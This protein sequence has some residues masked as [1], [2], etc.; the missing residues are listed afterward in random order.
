MGRTAKILVAGAGGA[1]SEGVIHSLNR[2]G[3]ETVGMGSE[4]T[5][6][7][8]SAASRKYW[9]P[10]ANAPE[11]K[12]RLLEILR[13]E[14]PD[15]VHFQNDLEIYHASL[16]RDEIVETGVK[17]FM[18]SHETIDACVHKYKSWQKFKAAGIKVPE[19]ILIHNEE[20]LRR[21]FDTLGKQQGNI[22]LR[23]SSIGGGGKG[24]LPTSSFEFAKAWIDHYKGWGDFVA[25]E[26]LT[27]D[28]VTWLSI[29]REGELIVAQGRARQGWTHGSRAV[30]GI[31]G[32]TKVGVTFSSPEL[33]RIAESTI[34]AVDPKPHGIYGV[35]L[36]YD[37]EGV[38]N[39]TEINIS[40][41][42]T[43]ILFFTEA[44]LNMPE[45]FANLALFGERPRLEKVRSPLKDGLMWLR[46][47]DRAPMLCTEADLNSQIDYGRHS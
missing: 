36:A 41:F 3:F 47:M 18:P 5:D 11:Y 40:R 33:D 31:T 34:R 27:K 21:A 29:W 38:P 9:V 37:A 10:Y 6:L 22:W 23:A 13:F 30:S 14:K 25:A 43:T 46:G 32:V 12:G 4:P 7:I 35:D 44:G 20:D 28:T 19:N 2:A 24:A 39:P 1:P 45:I 15:L 26:M 17:I 16:L 8:L 42:F